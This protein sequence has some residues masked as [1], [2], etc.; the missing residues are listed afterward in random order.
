M[1]KYAEF[2][3]FRE[4]NFITEA[5]G[6]ILDREARDLV[7]RRIEKS[8]RTETDFENVLYWRDELDA[9]SSHRKPERE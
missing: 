6:D 4:Q 9:L 3:A 2:Q 8:A 5:D 1:P 7:I